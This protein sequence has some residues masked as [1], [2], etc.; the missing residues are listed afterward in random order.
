MCLTAVWRKL[1][2]MTTT[3]TPRRRFTVLRTACLF[4]GTSSRLIADPMVMIDGSTI[5]PVD[6]GSGAAP[7][8]QAIVVDL[9][10]VTLLPG[11]IDTHVHLAF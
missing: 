3:L 6:H 10:G 2:C 5:S 4:D 8:D 11:L 9:P 7:P 1:D